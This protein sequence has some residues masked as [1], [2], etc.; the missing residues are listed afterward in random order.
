MD[1]YSPAIITVPANMS[2]VEIS[3][4]PDNGTK[5]VNNRKYTITVSAVSD[6]GTSY[7][8]DP[9]TISKYLQL[10][11][12]TY[13]AICYVHTYVAIIKLASYYCNASFALMI[14]THGIDL[15]M[16]MDKVSGYN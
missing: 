8:S 14:K 6:Q 3:K 2:S 4:F 16:Y 1:R 10:S 11:E 12:Y 15:Y 7:P 5:I 9:V 13:V